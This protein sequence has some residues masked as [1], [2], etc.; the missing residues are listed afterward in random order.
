MSEKGLLLLEAFDAL[1][2]QEQQELL[3]ALLKRTGWSDDS[4]SADAMTAVAEAAFLA[5][6]E[7]ERLAD[8]S[9]PR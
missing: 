2:R 5:L 7:E 6:D 4:L 3:L 9:Q 8:E 1:P